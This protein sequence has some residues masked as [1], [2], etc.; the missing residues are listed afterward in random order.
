MATQDDRE[1]QSW[2]PDDDDVV[3]VDLHS[4]DM[5][6][7]PHCRK[8]VAAYS[9]RCP[10]CKQLTSHKAHFHHPWWI[11]VT[12]SAMLVL[13]VVGLIGHHFGL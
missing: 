1:Y 5:I 11:V 3:S 12:A 6:T 13:L 10:Y 4:I 2:Q 9:Q 8:F 7:C